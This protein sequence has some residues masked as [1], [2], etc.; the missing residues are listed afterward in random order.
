MLTFT[1]TAEAICAVFVIVRVIVVVSAHASIESGD[2]EAL[3]PTGGLWVAEIV[4][5]L[6][7]IVTQEASSVDESPSTLPQPQ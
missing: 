4:A 6:G 5:V 2:R 7:V 1:P 3:S